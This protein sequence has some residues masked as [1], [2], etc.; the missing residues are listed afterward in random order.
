MSIGS[1]PR[2]GISLEGDRRPTLLGARIVRHLTQGPYGKRVLIGL[3]RDLSVPF[4]A[5][6]P[7]VPI[8]LRAFRAD[9]MPTLFP[10]SDGA[11]AER[12]RADVAWRLRM[13]EQGTLRSRCFV[14]VDE[15]AD[16]PCHI[17]WLTDGY[18]DAIRTAAALPVLSLA[19]SAF[20]RLQPD[21]VL[22]HTEE[23]D[24]PA[25]VAGFFR[26]E[27][28][29]EFFLKTACALGLAAAGFFGHGAWIDQP[30][31]CSALRP[32]AT[33]PR[34]TQFR[35]LSRPRSWGYSRFRHRAPAR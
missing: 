12:E 13:V 30:I 10:P 2:D 31:A 35:L 15:R 22:V 26:G 34:P 5:P 9:D 8:S 29:G 19:D 4:P 21:A 27:G 6:P 14:T 24:R 3:R 16:R 23:G 20:D 33:R 25:G 7:K 11:A 28:R 17:Q 32:A 18:S 1:G